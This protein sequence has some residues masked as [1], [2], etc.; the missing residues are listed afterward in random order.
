MDRKR[1]L[2]LTAFIVVFAI[3]A[4]LVS[5]G[6]GD[7]TDPRPTASLPD[8]RLIRLELTSF[9]RSHVLRNG[10][11][12]RRGLQRE[13]PRPLRNLLGPEISVIKTTTSTDTLI[14]F[15]SIGQPPGS[16]SRP[17]WGSFRVVADSGE[18]FDIGS[19]SS[20]NNLGDRPLAYPRLPIFPRRDAGFALTGT[21]DRLP[22]S[23]RVDNPLHGQ[24]FPAWS[25]DPSSAT[26]HLDGLDLVLGRT[27]LHLHGRGVSLGTDLEIYQE[28]HSVKDW[29]DTSYQLEDA[30]GNR[31]Y[32]LS[33]NEPVW[34]IQFE[35][36]RKSRAPWSPSEYQ[37]F[38]LDKL[39]AEAGYQVIDVPAPING[40]EIRRVWVGGPGEFIMANG[41]IT[42]AQ[43]ITSKRR[44]T[45]SSSS[46]RSDWKVTWARIVPWVFCESDRLP[47]GV[48]V[49]VFITDAR[50]RPVP[51]DYRGSI[52]N[53]SFSAKMF[54]LKSATNIVAPLNI[55]VAIQTNLHTEF[56]VNPAKLKRRGSTRPN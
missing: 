5:L 36:W 32:K 28:S 2:G 7:D 24:E 13:L 52:G 40:H 38:P 39:P 42:N 21:V 30:T 31:G 49:S 37:D 33:T 15:L 41:S 53:G 46:G 26:N 4:C 43:P 44:G 56:R 55:R 19:W 17:K 23:I 18:V 16:K 1:K 29:Y 45:T 20:G 9:G 10:P 25:A 11:D 54:E 27:Q 34:E 48:R 35:F 6:P 14:P 50:N 22:F 12:W 8:G 3:A 47:K 51:T